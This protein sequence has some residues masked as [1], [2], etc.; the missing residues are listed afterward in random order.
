[1]DEKQ[2]QKVLKRL[3]GKYKYHLIYKGAIQIP[4]SGDN[5]CRDVLRLLAEKETA[6]TRARAAMANV[7][8]NIKRIQKTITEGNTISANCICDAI[9]TTIAARRENA[10]LR[11]NTLLRVDPDGSVHKIECETCA[12]LKDLLRECLTQDIDKLI[13]KITATLEE[14]P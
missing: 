10:E 9:R 2:V 7:D 14:K 3:G 11:D 5:F 12:D 13:D 8:H 6:L 4:D 1:M